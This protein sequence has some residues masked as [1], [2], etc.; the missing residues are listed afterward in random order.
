MTFSFRAFVLSLSV[1]LFTGLASG[2]TSA[3]T[4]VNPPIR[5]GIEPWLG[6]GQ[7]HIAAREGFFQEQ[8]LAHVDLV[9][10]TL[11]AD[12]N[13]AL[14]SD[15]LDAANVATHTAIEFIARGI[16]IRIVALLDV[17]T[18]ADAI[19]S[20]GSASGIADLK[21]SEIA[22]EKGS[23]SDILLHYALKQNGM[24]IDDIVPVTMPAAEAGNA[25]VG[26]RVPAAVT[27]E[28]YLTLTKDRD[29]RV[30]TLYSAGGNPGLISD[31]LVVRETFLKERPDAVV[32]LLKSWQAALDLYASDIPHGRA[33]IAEAIGEKPQALQSAFDGVTYYSLQDNIDMLSG[34]FLTGIIPNVEAAAIDA[35]LLSGPVDMSEAVDGRFVEA[36]AE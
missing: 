35:G 29:G 9:N 8:G 26:G 23:T 15:Q 1:L 11:D 34:P 24:T 33:I 36:A 6:Y 7:W 27:Y 31:V 3:Q 17:S 12:I 22:F 14:A 19:I 10:F 25:L 32:A 18:T 2:T 13:A 16:P 20:N 5:M 4:P 21:G 28:P 30:N